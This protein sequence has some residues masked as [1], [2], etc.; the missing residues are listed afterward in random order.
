MPAKLL[1]LLPLLMASVLSLKLLLNTLLTVSPS[2]VV[3]S[4][5]M[6]VS[7][8]LPLATGASLTAVT[9]KVRVF[10]VM[11]VS[12]PLLAVPPLSW[13]LKPIVA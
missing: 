6:A 5:S 3:V 11:L 8:A 9:L 13:T 12:T 10:A 1:A 2:G 7:V 4:S